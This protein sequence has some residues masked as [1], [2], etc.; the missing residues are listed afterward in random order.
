LDRLEAGLKGIAGDVTG[1]RGE[2][3]E[4]RTDVTAL[5]VGQRA[6]AASHHRLEVKFEDRHQVVLAIADGLQALGEQV[7]RGFAEVRRKIRDTNAKI[8]TFI[9]AQSRT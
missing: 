6:L 2:V 8:D 1:V 5:S 9:R 7:E 3:T 4:M